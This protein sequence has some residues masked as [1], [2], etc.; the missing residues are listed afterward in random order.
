[1]D[2]ETEPII[3]RVTLDSPRIED[4]Y[5]L[6]KV[7]DLAKK[8]LLVRDFPPIVLMNEKKRLGK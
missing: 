5:V 2:K 4:L 3:G 1:M 7:D 6:L 8:P